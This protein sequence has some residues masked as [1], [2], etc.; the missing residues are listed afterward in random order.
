MESNLESI[1]KI[2]SE[3]KSS[4]EKLLPY[5]DWLTANVKK[6]VMNTYGEDGVAENS[7]QFPVYDSTLMSFVRTCNATGKMDRNYV[8]TFSKNRLRTVQDELRFIEKAQMQ[9]FQDLW[10]ILARY[11][12]KGNTKGLVWAEG[13]TEGVYLKVILKM[14]DMINFWD[15]K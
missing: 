13:V 9:Q 1:E 2:I 12:I 11:I 10:N 8:Y 5:V 14:R 3:N 6:T 4:M 15:R 7:V